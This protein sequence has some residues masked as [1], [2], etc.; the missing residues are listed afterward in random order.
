MDQRVRHVTGPQGLRSR[1]LLVL[2]VLAGVVA[3]HGLGPVASSVPSGTVAAGTHRAAVAAEA[4]AHADGA[5]GCDCAHAD[6]HGRG[7]GHTEHADET[8]AAGGTSA[9]PVLPALAPGELVPAV[10]DTPAAALAVTRDGRAPPSLSE[11][12][13]LRI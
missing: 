1:V 9:A 5:D 6:D 3:M 13:L 11:L 2:A 8:C 10:A 12:Q 4:H 7:G